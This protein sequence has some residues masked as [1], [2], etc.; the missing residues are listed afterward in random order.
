MIAVMLGT[1]LKP[2]VER[3]E[4]VGSIRRV[5]EEVGDAELLFIPRRTT[6]QADMFSEETFDCADEFL[7]RQLAAC[8]LSKRVGERGTTSWGLAN[9]LAVHVAS[10]MPVDLFATTLENW[11]VSLVVRTG[12]KETNLRLTTG[13]RARNRTLNAYGCGV[14]D[15]QTGEILPAFSEE[16]VFALC[17]VPFLPPE[18][19]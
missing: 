13:A 15:I 18:R 16:D 3:I 17:G 6:R 5:K 11:W 2:F 19:R 4:I 9:K 12:S 7:N 10:G 14:T 8:A 1:E